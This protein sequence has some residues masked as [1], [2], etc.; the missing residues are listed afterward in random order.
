MSQEKPIQIEEWVEKKEL[1]GLELHPVYLDI[2]NEII[3][4][5]KVA[6]ISQYFLDN[7]A[8][9]LGPTLTLLI[10]RLRRYCYYNKLTKEKRDWCYPKHDTLAEEIGV[11]RWTVIRELQ[12]PM[13]KHFIKREKR[14]TY[15]TR[16]KKKI[17]TSD[18]YYITMDEP[19]IPEDHERLKE[20][21]L[22]KISDDEKQNENKLVDLSSN[23]QLRS[24]ES[25]ENP[26][27]KLQSATKDS[28][29]KLLQESLRLKGTLNNVNVKNAFDKTFKN[30]EEDEDLKIRIRL[31]VQDMLDTLQDQKSKPFYTLVAR[32]VLQAHGDPQ[33]IHRALSE[34][35]AEAMMGNIRKSKG[36]YFTDLIKRY[37]EQ[38]GIELKKR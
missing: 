17:R 4:P 33:L 36:A 7:W 24:E 6:V 37:C 11:S 1:D 2:K 20:E 8:P 12:K 10:I 5:E 29:S 18:M 3:V 38:N 23:L 16:L 25:V 9:R 21:F 28:C 19:L 22:E 13:A 32:K 27:P 31:T 14:Y 30:Q 26:S 34:V 35:R 15:D